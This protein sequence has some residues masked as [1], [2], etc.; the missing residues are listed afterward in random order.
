VRRAFVAVSKRA[1]RAPVRDEKLFSEVLVT[2][3]F[4][5]LLVTALSLGLVHTLIGPDHYLPFIVLGRA[6][7]WTMRKTMLL[8]ALCGAAHVMSS[9]VVGSLGIALGWSLG[10]M[11]WFEGIRGS[12]AGWALIVFGAAYFTWGMV[13]ARRG[14]SHVHAHQDGTVHRHGH[15][16]DHLTDDVTHANQPHE[17]TAHVRSHRRT[18]WALFIVFVLGPCEPLIPLLLVPAAEH[19]AAGIAAV[20]LAFGGA[21]IVTM[22]AVVAAGSIGLRLFRF[23]RLERY[24]HALSGAAVAV[25]GLLIAVVGL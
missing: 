4:A 12:A 3:T 23:G 10:G 22:L 25:S 13:R 17:E 16:H 19:S 8:T 1:L 21:T 18:A 2:D 15:D 9:I 14:H 11:E 20:A 6:E 7:G 5:V 24:V